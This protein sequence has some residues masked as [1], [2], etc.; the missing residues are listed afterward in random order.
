MNEEERN[1]N[2]DGAVTFRGRQWQDYVLM[3]G[4][5]LFAILLLPT[6]L[7]PNA[8]VPLTTS[9]LTGSVL[10]VFSYTFYTMNLKLSTLT[11]LMSGVMWLLI[12]IF[13]SG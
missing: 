3:G 5:L 12:A 7:N 8:M 6:L 10:L 4:N 9:L 2:N 1:N 13:R 11:S